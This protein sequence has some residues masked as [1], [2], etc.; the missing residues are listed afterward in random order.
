M[1]YIGLATHVCWRL[2]A[3]SWLQSN[4]F[5]DRYAAAHRCTRSEVDSHEEEVWD[6]VNL[7][8]VLDLC[9]IVMMVGRFGGV[10]ARHV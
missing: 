1:L 8:P 5:T 4:Q 10:P 9:G 6:G 2:G 3:V 7:C